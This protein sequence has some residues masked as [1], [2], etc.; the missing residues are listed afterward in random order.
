MSDV[1]TL[2]N[3]L[4]QIPEEILTR[5]LIS[6]TDVY[7]QELARFNALMQN[8]NNPNVPEVQARL[9]RAAELSWELCGLESSIREAIESLVE[10]L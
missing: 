4:L 8:S 2:K 3:A 5:G 1:E 7:Y 9:N 10:S 6:Q